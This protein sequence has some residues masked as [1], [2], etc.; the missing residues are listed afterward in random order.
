MRLIE[1]ER[2][3]VFPGAPTLFQS[4]LDAPGPGRARPVLAAARRHRRGRR[5]RRAHRADARPRAQGLAI[6]HVVTAFGMTEAV[7][8]TMCRDGDSAET[9]ATTYGR[10]IPGMETRIDDNG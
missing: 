2:I 1:S 7:V 10:A 3:T 4:L 8:V 9:V 6:D 5:T